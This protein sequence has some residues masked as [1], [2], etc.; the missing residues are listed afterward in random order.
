MTECA[1]NIF[2]F[3][4]RFP[5]FFFCFTEIT[6]SPRLTAPS[7][8]HGECSDSE[9]YG[10]ECRFSCDAGYELK[11]SASVLCDAKGWNASTP[12]CKSKCAS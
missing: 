12:R 10:S 9:N 2:T 5:S 4:N 3:L 1:A 11:G 7:D 6:C 8:G